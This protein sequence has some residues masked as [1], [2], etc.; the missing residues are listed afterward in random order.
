MSGFDS[1]AA[2]LQTRSLGR[3]LEIRDT[4]TSTMDDARAALTRGAPSGH[5][6]VAD[7]QS[8]GRGTH[9][10]TWTSPAGSDLYVSFIA[11][12]KV[13]MERLPA[14]A[15]AVGLGIADAIAERLS[16]EVVRVKWPNDVLVSGSKCAGILIETR[17][18][19]EGVD[20]VIVGFGMN[21]NR[22][23][24][25]PGA[26]SH[27]T[28][29]ALE[30]GHNFDRVDVLGSVLL[31]VEQAIDLWENG[32]LARTIEALD[33]RLAYRG[34]CVRL[35]DTMGTLLGLAEDGSLRIATSEG[36][37]VFSAG[38]LALVTSDAASA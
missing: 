6:I 7:T 16:P 22:R 18:T 24:F 19:S 30:A 21:V 11:R 12:P 29:L 26:L 35:D 9:G 14:M 37:R 23:E 5:V 27:P 20:G 10:R 25:E 17:A 33:A 2:T 15:L 1:L 36:E 38:R 28:S 4:T 32:A 13:A 31:H 34:Q 3:S 8:Q